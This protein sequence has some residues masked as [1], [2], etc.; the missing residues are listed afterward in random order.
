MP[1]ILLLPLVATCLETIYVWIWRMYLCLSVV[2]TVWGYV[3][4]Y[5]VYLPL[6]KIVGFALECFVSLCRGC[7]FVLFV[8]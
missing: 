2:V 4:M 7:W 8:L 6:L 1:S 3:G 5:V